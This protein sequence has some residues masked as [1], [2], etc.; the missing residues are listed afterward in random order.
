MK[1]KD[2]HF[3]YMKQQVNKVLNDNPDL[4]AQYKKAGLSD[5]RFN[6]DLLYRAN[7]NKWI[8]DTLYDYLNDTH[9]DTAIRKITGKGN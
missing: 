3:N 9:I 5:M 2:D 1:M 7:L 6:W 8:C 4:Y